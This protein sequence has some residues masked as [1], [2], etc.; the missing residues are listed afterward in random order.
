M[1]IN[2]QMGAVQEWVAI[3]KRRPHF[4]TVRAPWEHAEPRSGARCEVPIHVITDW[5]ISDHMNSNEQYVTSDIIAY[6]L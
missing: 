2:S 1:Y 4:Q 6:Y 3:H 5:P